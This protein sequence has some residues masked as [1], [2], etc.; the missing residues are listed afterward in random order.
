MLT[1]TEPKET[2]KCYDLI[3]SIVQNVFNVENWFK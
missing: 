2:L 1:Q 3:K